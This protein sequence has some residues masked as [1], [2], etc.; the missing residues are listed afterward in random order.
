MMINASKVSENDR[1]RSL[2]NGF[3]HSD[4]G[5]LPLSCICIELQEEVK[6][7]GCLNSV[8]AVR[9]GREAGFTRYKQE[10]KGDIPV[11]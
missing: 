10:G 7:T 9:G 4:L 1:G 3:T 2:D 11:K 5:K 8:P 6:A